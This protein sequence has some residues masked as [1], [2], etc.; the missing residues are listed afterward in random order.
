MQ[1]LNE[2]KTLRRV[3]L[4]HHS[5]DAPCSPIADPEELGQASPTI[6]YLNLS[7]ARGF[8]CPNTAKSGLERS[9]N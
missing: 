4:S 7:Y 6:I 5:A 2:I 1:L 8:I 9:R 3:L